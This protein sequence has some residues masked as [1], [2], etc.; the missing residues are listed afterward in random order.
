MRTGDS[1]LQYK[2]LN[3]LYYLL[4][5]LNDV[6]LT[7]VAWQTGYSHAKHGILKK[8]GNDKWVRAVVLSA[9]P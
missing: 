2:H 6:F 3:L 8:Q 9:N 1:C 4:G 5:H 7:S